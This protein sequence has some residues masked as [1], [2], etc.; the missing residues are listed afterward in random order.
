MR[1]DSGHGRIRKNKKYDKPKKSLMEKSIRLFF[2]KEKQSKSC[3]L[4]TLPS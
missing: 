3:P 1:P 2:Y 4:T